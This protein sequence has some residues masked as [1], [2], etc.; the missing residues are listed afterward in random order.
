[1]KSMIRRKKEKRE[2]DDGRRLWDR[3]PAGAARGPY[4]RRKVSPMVGKKNRG[5]IAG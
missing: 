2:Y 4:K 3:L 5:R 1:M